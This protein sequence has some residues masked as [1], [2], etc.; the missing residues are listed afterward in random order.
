MQV[1]LERGGQVIAQRFYGGATLG[2]VVQVSMDRP[3][4]DRVASETEKLWLQENARKA[5]VWFT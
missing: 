3:T 4:W 5:Q 2:T 1:K